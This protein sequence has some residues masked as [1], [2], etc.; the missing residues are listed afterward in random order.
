MDV[1]E[2]I[3][4]YKFAYERVCL[5]PDTSENIEQGLSLGGYKILES[6]KIF[7]SDWQ[8]IDFRK[9]KVWLYNE[10]TNKIVEIENFEQLLEKTKLVKRALH[11]DCSG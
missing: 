9:T 4:K 10:K 6:I 5:Y 1:S 2:K 7:R 3:E 8:Q 11:T